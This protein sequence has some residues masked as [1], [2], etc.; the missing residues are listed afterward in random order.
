M[1]STIKKKKKDMSV[2]GHKYIQGVQGGPERLTFDSN[3]MKA[4]LTLT[5]VY[6]LVLRKLH[7]KNLSFYI[8][9]MQLFIPT[10]SQGCCQK[11]I[12]FWISKVL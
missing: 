10:T 7:L 12:K 4:L 3:N 11:P 2:G 1:V 9:K 6:L 8:C 5:R